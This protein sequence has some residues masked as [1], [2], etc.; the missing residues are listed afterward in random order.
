MLFTQHMSAKTS[1]LRSGAQR[2]ALRRTRASSMRCRCCARQLR[3]ARHIKRDGQRAGAACAMRAWRCCARARRGQPGSAA[4]CFR[5]ARAAS[6]MLVQPAR[7]G[8]SARALC[9]R[10]R[11][12]YLYGSCARYVTALFVSVAAYVA[13]SCRACYTNHVLR[14]APLR[15]RS[16]RYGARA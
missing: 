7:G 4:L 1:I 14:G 9:A 13:F 8:A 10:Q 3:Y 11:Y 6:E 2:C 12:I 15:R 16:T 5:R